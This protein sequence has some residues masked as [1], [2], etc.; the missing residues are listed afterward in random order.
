[1]ENPNQKF[2]AGEDLSNK[3][4]EIADDS[5]TW[6][7][8]TE[9]NQ[10]DATEQNPGDSIDLKEPGVGNLE[11]PDEDINVETDLINDLEVE[12]NANSKKDIEASNFEKGSETSNFEGNLHAILESFSSF[13]KEQ[14][15]LKNESL[16][17]LEDDIDYEKGLSQAKKS[18]QDRLDRVLKPKNVEDRP[19]E[20]PEEKA[21]RL[22]YYQNK[23]GEWYIQ[24]GP[25]KSKF[26][27]R[28]DN[29]ELDLKNPELGNMLDKLSEKYGIEPYDYGGIK[30]R[31]LEEPKFLEGKDE[32]YFENFFRAVCIS[33][34]DGREIFKFSSEELAKL[35]DTEIKFYEI[36]QKEL[37]DNEQNKLRYVSKM[38]VDIAQNFS[39]DL[40]T[41]DFTEQLA[42]KCLE[43][44][45]DG[46]KGYKKYR[47]AY[48]L[49]RGMSVNHSDSG[50]AKG[51]FDYADE[52]LED[53]EKI[54]K[55]NT[56]FDVLCSYV[57]QHGLRED[58]V[59]G[60]REN[61]IPLI[62]SKDPEVETLIQGGNIFGT[63]DGE[64]GIGDYIEE[65][66]ATRVNPKNI[67]W[68]IRLY[69]E[70]PTSDF[71]KFEQNRKDALRIEGSIIG[72]HD[73]IHDERPNTHEILKTIEEYYD[74]RN[75]EIAHKAAA[76][77]LIKF[78]EEKH[79]HLTPNVFDDEAYD[80]PIKYMADYQHGKEGR[81][82]ERAIDILRRLVKNTA[83]DLLNAPKTKDEVLNQLFKDINPRIN[84]E[85][86]KIDLDIEEVA[87]AVVRIN[88]LLEENQNTLGLFPSTISAV[89]YL[90]KM[91]AYALRGLSKKQAQEIVFDPNFKEI[92][93]FSQLT[94]SDGYDKP[95]FE[96]QY[97]KI[98][99][100]ASTAYGENGVDDSK[101][102]EAL[103]DLSQMILK[104]AD[105][106]AKVYKEEGKN[107]SGSIWSGNL[108]HELI[109]LFEK[110]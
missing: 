50:L 96:S 30:G 16:G 101:I 58:T 68:L 22:G 90:D 85:T 63:G 9:V 72:A 87:P 20:T 47:I 81:P 27:D 100:E 45:R 31:I 21:K 41:D 73:F 11:N 13:E 28:A 78:E 93:R 29:F 14:K 102:S 43:S 103:K 92:V 26:D 65:C 35:T 107:Q 34:F 19:F 15:S 59:A 88:Q 105:A 84:E 106:L 70:I 2:S 51:C 18:I 54:T 104:N 42:K 94:S 97:N 98:L 33:G 17:E 86:G 109:G 99:K 77:K 67:D 60:F 8:D 80:R 79:F 46:T 62:E 89:A 74:S 23:K 36:A 91:S 64:Y 6:G 1:M 52:L 3:W 83:P 110:V 108:S 44:D 55:Y 39:S 75:D 4:S 48:N 69:H 25:E 66:L 24:I 82:D 95:K 5:K 40:F 71:A 32:Q 56:A 76:E 10:N 7:S 12:N 61:V 57:R 38:A 37:G 53:D 49:V